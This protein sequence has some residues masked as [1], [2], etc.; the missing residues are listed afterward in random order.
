MRLSLSGNGCI[1]YHKGRE[2]EKA[3]GRADRQAIPNRRSPR[4]DRESYAE[5]RPQNWNN[6][7]R[8]AD[9]G[10]GEALAD[11]RVVVLFFGRRL[12]QL[13]V[14]ARGDVVILADLTAGELDFQSFRIFLITNLGN[15]DRGNEDPMHTKGPLSPERR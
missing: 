3:E 4:R 14:N 1:R 11:P 2:K 5:R 9:P 15:I 10:A 8:S 7:R 6:Q 13:V 12:H